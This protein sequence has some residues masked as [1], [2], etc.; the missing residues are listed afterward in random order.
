MQS[1][2]RGA[3]YFRLCLCQGG[4]EIDL[5][6]INLLSAQK[7][8]DNHVTEIMKDPVLATASLPG[9][10]E[11]RPSRSTQK[12]DMERQKGLWPAPQQFSRPSPRPLLAPTFVRHALSLHSRLVSPATPPFA[13]RIPD[14]VLRLRKHL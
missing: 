6:G 14:P 7:E 5:A 13:P 1:E 11:T 12:R 10:F 9:L 4:N 2:N 8:L 3:E